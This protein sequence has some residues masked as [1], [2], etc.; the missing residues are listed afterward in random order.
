[1]APGIAFT[2]AAKAGIG[3]SRVL[4][5]DAIR[6]A[7]GNS[8]EEGE[9]VFSTPSGSFAKTAL[10]Q[11]LENLDWADALLLAGDFGRNSETAMLLEQI[12]EKYTGPVTLAQDSLDYFIN[13]VG[14][15]TAREDTLIV[16][17]LTKLQKMTKAGM[18]SLIIQHKM[19]LQALVGLLNS[20]SRESKLKLLTYHNGNY[21]YA[22]AGMVSTTPAQEI[23]NWEIPLAA[24]ISTSR[25]QHPGKSFESVTSAIYEYVKV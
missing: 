15:L 9:F 3:T 12:L 25:I 8:F 7:I 19:S 20:W 16:T 6:K 24:A 14:K 23:N 21:I 11:I 10:N 13:D 18:P 1:M 22:E 5:P 2:A 4:L 17:N